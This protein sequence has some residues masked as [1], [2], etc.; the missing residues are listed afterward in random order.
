MYDTDFPNAISQIEQALVERRTYFVSTSIATY[1]SSPILAKVQEGEE[2]RDHKN[3]QA[4][5]THFHNIFVAS[6]N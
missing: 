4:Y 2:I 5:T 6:P 3:A 1:M